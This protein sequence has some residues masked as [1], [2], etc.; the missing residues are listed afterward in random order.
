MSLLHDYCKKIFYNIKIWTTLRKFR[1]S[2]MLYLRKQAPINW[3]WQVVASRLNLAEYSSR[4]AILMLQGNILLSKTWNAVLSSQNSCTEQTFLKGVLLAGRQHWN[5]LNSG[6]R[7]IG[8]L[9]KK[10]KKVWTFDKTEKFTHSESP[11]S[12]VRFSLKN[13]LVSL[14][15]SF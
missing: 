9:H 1:G 2:Y 13:P 5:I 12:S 7:G 8:F 6:F 10:K 14:F 11:I 3:F 4:R 15:G